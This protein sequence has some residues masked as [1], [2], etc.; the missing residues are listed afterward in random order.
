MALP[1]GSPV[2][3]PR[4]HRTPSAGPTLHV[5]AD[6]AGHP[7]ARTTHLHSCTDHPA[8]NSWT[9][10]LPVRPAALSPPPHSPGPPPPSA[11][12]APFASPWGS[13]RRSTAP[14]AA[15][16]TAAGGRGAAAGRPRRG[17]GGAW[18]AAA[19]RGAE[20]EEEEEEEKEEETRSR[21]LIRVWPRRAPRPPQAASMPLSP[22]RL[23]PTPSPSR[24][25]GHPSFHPVIGR[26]P[27]P[28]PDT[29]RAES[30]ARPLR[31]R[32]SARPDP[33]G[34][35]ACRVRAGGGVLAATGG[36]LEGGSGDGTA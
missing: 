28:E 8:P 18:R 11:G 2:R 19:R 16:A 3:V 13:R 29:G 24:P 20:Q 6:K 34:E 5:D 12:A 35:A 25:S 26:S 36:S 4:P 32:R 17:R 21:D 7:V 15:A 22:A 9:H 23:P 31:R 14:A 33:R 1:F 30:R 27:Y 10:V